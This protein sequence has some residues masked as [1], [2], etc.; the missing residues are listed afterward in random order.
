MRK[1]LKNIDN[2]YSPL[3]LQI[4]RSEITDCIDAI[5]YD[6]TVNNSGIGDFYG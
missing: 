6:I 1:H 5:I 2:S 4:D 3:T